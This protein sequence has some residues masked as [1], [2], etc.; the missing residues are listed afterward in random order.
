MFRHDGG[1]KRLH[2]ALLALVQEF[3][4]EMVVVCLPTEWIKYHDEGNILSSLILCQYTEHGRIAITVPAH[5]VRF[6]EEVMV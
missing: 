6:E 4:A 2:D 3:G 1:E 5:N